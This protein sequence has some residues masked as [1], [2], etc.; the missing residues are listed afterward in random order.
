MY[1]QFA[2]LCKKKKVTAYRVA[3][4]TGIPQATFSQWKHGITQP[5]VDK[6]MILADYFDVPVEYFLKKMK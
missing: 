1:E 2:K 4:D 6:I 3:E 5:K